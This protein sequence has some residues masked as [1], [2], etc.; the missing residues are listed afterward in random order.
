MQ[1]LSLTCYGGVGAVTGAN[2]LLEGSPGKFLIDC[3]LRQ[4]DR[5]GEAE[6]YEPFPY[7]PKSIKALFVTHAHMDHIG[8]IPKL[9]HDGFKGIIYSTRETKLVVPYM[10]DDALSLLKRE[11]SERQVAPLYDEKDI[12]KAL[13]L[14]QEVPY[15]K[16][17]DLGNGLKFLLKDAGHI[18][19]SAMIEFSCSERKMLFTGDLGNSPSILLHD[20]ESPKGTD[21]LLME[22]VYGDR[23][24]ESKTERDDR[25][26]MILTETIGRGGAVII[27][28]FSLERT[29]NILYSL[30]NLIEDK[31]IPSVPVFLDSP[32][33]IK[34]TEVY[35][36]EQQNFKQSIQDEIKSGDDIFNFP[37]LKFT[38]QTKDSLAIEKT[39]NPKIILAGSGMSSGGRVTR[40]EVDHLGD[41]K[42]TILL[43]GYQSIGTFGRRL[44][45][46]AK[47]VRLE[48]RDINVRAHIE[49]I[50]GFSSHK[51]S[52]HMVF[53]VEECAETVKKVF[54][55][56]GEPKAS[57][58]LIQKL[59]DNLGV[60]AMYPEKGK[61]YDLE[62]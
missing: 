53:F 48:G 23:N 12:D 28:A 36:E 46:G 52:D 1:K 21:Y 19:G 60:D 32:L 33:A 37:K 47:Q 5:F 61:R 51:D 11:A 18:L 8:R 22:S 50:Q 62:F 35:R 6:N 44:Q 31:K 20:T 15:R 55:C 40:H 58:F 4:G 39:P 25:L 59:R 2:F 56:M 49:N 24:H 29:Q 27:P 17:S 34:V 41:P 26:K 38:L 43:V 42:S 3:G 45:D 54:V 14:W 13:S 16:E 30:N 9:V 10:F 57:L 7:D